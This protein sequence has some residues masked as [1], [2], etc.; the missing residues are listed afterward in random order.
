MAEAA[1]RRRV[2]SDKTAFVNIFP[3]LL[4]ELVEDIKTNYPDFDKGAIEWFRGVCF[5]F[6]F[7]CSFLR[8]CFCPCLWVLTVWQSFEYN[9]L[10]GKMNRGLSVLDTY[11]HLKTS[12]EPTA[13]V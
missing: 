13:Q 11:R 3:S 10:G 8:V 7:D 2:E 6:F 1:K 9:C 12:S 5:F 4:E